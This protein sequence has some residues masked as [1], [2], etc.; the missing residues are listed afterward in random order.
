M[1][2]TDVVGYIEEVVGPATLFATPGA[3]VGGSTPNELV[4]FWAF[5]DTAA[6]YLD[7]HGVLKN[8]GGGGITVEVKW[9]A[10]TATTGDVL[11]GGAFQRLNDD[12][13]DVD[14]SFTYDYNN[15]AAATAPSASGE[16]SYDTITF[17]NGADMDSTANNEEFIFRL[18]RLPT[19]GADTM[20]G[21]AQMVSLVIRE[22]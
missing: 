8:Y 6:E 11:W 20:V 17:T 21:D 22:T 2:T 10:A 4:A 3:R 12:A 15:A 7:F 19:D 5:D 9:M 16:N 14:T 13:Q 1:A 18:R